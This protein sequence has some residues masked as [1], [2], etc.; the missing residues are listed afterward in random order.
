MSDPV[1][2]IDSVRVAPAPRVPPPGRRRP[3]REG[4]A[5]GEERGRRPALSE[6]FDGEGDEPSHVDVTA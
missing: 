5:G 4:G 3:P 1:A 2:P 6:P